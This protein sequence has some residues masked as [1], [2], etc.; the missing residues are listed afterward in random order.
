MQTSFARVGPALTEQET[1]SP[2]LPLAERSPGA[3]GL[4]PIALLQRCI[5]RPQLIALHAE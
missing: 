3:L 2:R 1:P 5:H 4:V